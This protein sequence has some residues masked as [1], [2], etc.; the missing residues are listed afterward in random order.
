MK[1]QG[2]GRPRFAPLQDAARVKGAQ[3][4]RTEAP[5]GERVAVSSQ[6]KLLA[7]VRG[8]EVPDASRVQSLKDAIS[9]GTFQVDAQRV[10]EAM[11]REEA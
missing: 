5:Q 4:Q 11:I 8:P 6:S 3:G 9:N 7:E 10:A 1:V 2:P